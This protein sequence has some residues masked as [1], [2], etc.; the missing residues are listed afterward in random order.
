MLHVL[1]T[2]AGGLG[3]VVYAILDGLDR[4]EFK[5]AAAFGP[6][7]PMDQQFRARG[8]EVFPVRMRRGMSLMNVLG[9]LDLVRLLRRE[10]FDIVHAHSSI[11]GV[12]ARAAA[13][14]AGVPMVVFTLHGYATLDFDR[15]PLRPLLWTIEKLMD[16][17]TDGYV[18]ICQYVK[19]T[20]SDRKLVDPDRV[21]VIYNGVDPGL[22][23]QFL[24]FAKVRRELGVTAGG[25]L[26]G[27][28]GL[29]EVQKG[30][31]YLIEAMPTVLR[32]FP[33][34]QLVLVGDGP[35]RE[36]LEA[37]TQRLGISESVTFA[38]WRKDA[39]TLLRVFDLF[40]L[41]SLQE[42]FSV[43]LLEAMAQARPIVATAV[44]GNPEAIV[45]RETGWLVPPGNSDAIAEG[46][47]ALL[48][49]PE[50]AGQLG[51]A[52][53]QRVLDLFTM[54]TMQDQYAA[55]YCKLLTGKGT[56]P[57]VIDS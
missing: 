49:Q 13:K 37:L 18:A 38:G 15:S 46:L 2:T 16:H 34:C 26:I 12:L 42:G 20:W 25:P 55:L 44:A 31:R 30:T 50:W 10:R 52:G 27:T 28:V 56:W 9:F 47:S 33:A 3:Q 57:C 11:A 7:Y 43:A 21:T 5:V 51:D 8:I 1:T 53:R 19:N 54:Q 39:A 45:H 32:E 48:R 4:R 14:L 17:C 29:H 35:L 22:L 41:P 24:D 40:C 6:G 23:E 36:E